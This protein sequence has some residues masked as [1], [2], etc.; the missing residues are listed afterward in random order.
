MEEYI[1]IIVKCNNDY[2]K[3]LQFLTSL[4]DYKFKFWYLFKVGDLRLR[5]LKSDKDKIIE[6]LN[7]NF[8]NYI[9]DIYEP[10]IYLFGGE[11]NINNIHRIFVEITKIFLTK[12]YNINNSLEVKISLL[13][14]YI[15]LYKL[16]YFEEWDVWRKINENRKLD[17]NIRRE[18]I[19]NNL[20]SIYRVI[21]NYKFY[22][23]EIEFEELTKS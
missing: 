16:D 5:V 18:I 2:K 6:R 1:T 9:I 13:N 15:K 19:L 20:D 8:F 14:Y 3:I 10:E 17:K 23:K 21:Q 4:I 11:K 7:M 12:I 22:I